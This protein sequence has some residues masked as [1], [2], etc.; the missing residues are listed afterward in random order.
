[1]RVA[2]DT[3]RLTDLFAGDQD[4]ATQLNQSEAVYVPLPV[5]AEAK[6]GYLGGS[7][8]AENEANL[9]RFMQEPFVHLLNPDGETSD[10]YATLRIQLRAMGTPIPINDLWIA[11]LCLQHNLWLITRDNHFRKIPQLRTIWP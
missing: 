5:L 10:Y 9:M 1:M 2:L 8:R 7:R 4:L 3:N 6:V 11:S